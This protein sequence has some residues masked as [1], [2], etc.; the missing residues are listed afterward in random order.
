MIRILICSPP[1]EQSGELSREHLERLYVFALMWSAGAVLELDDRKKLELWLRGNDAFSLDL[2]E[3]P[4]GSEDTMFDFHVTADGTHA[5]P[6]P[7]WGLDVNSMNVF[8][9]VQ[10]ISRRVAPTTSLMSTNHV[11]SASSLSHLG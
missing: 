11:Y 5:L 9:N 8:H 2:P 6:L 3:V 7:L 1:Q 4:P 10:R